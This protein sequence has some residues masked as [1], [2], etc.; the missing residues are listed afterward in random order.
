MRKAER[1]RLLTV[2]DVA[3]RLECSTRRVRMIPAGELP[4]LAMDARGVRKYDPADLDR[5]VRNR[6][7]RGD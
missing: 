1:G 3:M 6:T 2:E 7:V 5:Y 4:Y